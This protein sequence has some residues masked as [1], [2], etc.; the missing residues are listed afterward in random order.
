[1]TSVRP[2]G[3]TTPTWPMVQRSS[4]HVVRSDTLME[5]ALGDLYSEQAVANGVTTEKADVIFASLPYRIMAGLRVPVY[6][7]IREHDADF[8]A[9]LE[10]GGLPARLGRGRLRACS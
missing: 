7:Q 5:I 3:S 4:T 6:D 9:R 10:A 2:C 1:M 8:Y